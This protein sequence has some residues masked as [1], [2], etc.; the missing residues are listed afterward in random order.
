MAGKH[1]I[2]LFISEDG[3]LKV[4]IKGVKGP[5]CV[6]ALEAAMKNVGPV[7]DQALTAEYYSSEQ[8]I[9]GNKIK[10]K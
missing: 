9:T 10:N 1:E 5:S 3:E 4:H 8:S 2:E 7:K 6:K